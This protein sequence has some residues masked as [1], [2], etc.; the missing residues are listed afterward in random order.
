MRELFIILHIAIALVPW[1]VAIFFRHPIVL[2]LCLAGEILVMVQWLV[3][4]YCLMNPLENEGSKESYVMRR[5]A[6]WMRVSLENFQQG[7]VLV[8]TA[9]PS[10]LMLSKIAGYLGL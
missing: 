4:G 5:L 1:T 10:F 7:L 2:M 8:N 6:E 3:F 9:S